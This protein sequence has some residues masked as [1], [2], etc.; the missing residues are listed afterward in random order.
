MVT[1]PKNLT[2]SEHALIEA[3]PKLPALAE[4]RPTNI[5]IIEWL[6]PGERQTGNELHLWM[7]QQ[8]PRWSIYNQCTSK[9]E[10]IR[11]IERA[12]NYAHQS[13]MVPILHI[14]AHGGTSGLA[15]SRDASGELLAWAELTIPLQ[16]L[17]VATNCNLIVVV[18]ACLGFAAIQALTKGPRA[19]AAALVGPDATLNESDLLLGTKEFYRRFKDENPRLTFIAESASREMR[20]ADFEIEPFA[21]LAYETFVE[22]L[23]R[24]IRPAERRAR[25]ERLRQ[26]MH[27]E[28]SFSAEEIERRLAELPELLP[29]DQLQQIWDYMFMIDLEPKNEERFGLNW[30]EIAGRI[31]AAQLV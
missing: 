19:P 2:T 9:N 13:G 6:S 4:V 26:R 28:T 30:K 17:N 12:A 31:L 20:T 23:V 22:Q 15:P 7:E 14:D 18:A 24:D 16:Q 8:R 29:S 1:L 10:V 27:Q 5:W 21:T 3:L 11:S 25:L